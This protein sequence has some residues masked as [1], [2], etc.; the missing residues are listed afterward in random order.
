MMASLILNQ[1]YIEFTAMQA[2]IQ[3]LWLQLLLHFVLYHYCSH[4]LFFSPTKMNIEPG[5]AMICALLA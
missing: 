1:T 2:Y 4:D 5:E 3:F